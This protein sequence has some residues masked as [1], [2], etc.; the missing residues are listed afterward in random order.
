M[1][2]WWNFSDENVRNDFFVCYS[3]NSSYYI[4]QSA[5]QSTIRPIIQSIN[6][7]FKYLFEVDGLTS[8]CP[9]AETAHPNI[10]NVSGIIFLV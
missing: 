5:N 9:G 6:Q 1:N 8:F 3:V 2:A 7:S 4:G 10:K